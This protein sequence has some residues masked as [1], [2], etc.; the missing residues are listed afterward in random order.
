MHC[1]HY[2][3][4]WVWMCSGRTLFTKQAADFQILV[5]QL[6]GVWRGPELGEGIREGL[7]VDQ[8]GRCTEDGMDA[9]RDDSGKLRTRL[10]KVSKGSLD[11]ATGEDAAI[12]I[13]N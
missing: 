5:C 6:L 12:G 13:W 4:E 2:V 10:Q 3:N 7:T 1:R 8:Y 11:A 9:E